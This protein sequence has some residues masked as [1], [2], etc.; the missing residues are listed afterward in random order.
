MKAYKRNNQGQF[1]KI[2]FSQSKFAG[3]RLLIATVAIGAFINWLYTP[4]ELARP[5]VGEV[6]AIEPKPSVETI[7]LPPITEKQRILNYIVEKFG[8]DADK[9]ITIIGTCEN[10]TWDQS[11]TNTNRNGTKD[12]GLA[13]INDANSKLCKGLDFQHNWKDNI[14]CAKRIKDSQGFSAWAC[15]DRVGIVPF[16]KK[17]AK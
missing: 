17:G 14:D 15:S 6:V 7:V 9:M 2:P 11:R 8:D 10:G 4:V 13:Q 1:V 12:W 16:Y 3:L 5:V